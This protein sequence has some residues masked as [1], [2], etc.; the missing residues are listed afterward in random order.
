MQGGGW[1][2][3]LSFNDSDTRSEVVILPP[4]QWGR[5]VKPHP[6]N[7]V[8]SSVRIMCIWMKEIGLGLLA[9]INKFSFLCISYKVPFISFT[10]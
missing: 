9:Y 7:R 2:Y 4:L 8:W 1:A 3:F 6:K 10:L 5:G